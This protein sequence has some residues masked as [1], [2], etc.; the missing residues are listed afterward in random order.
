MG[1]LCGLR[2]A[3]ARVGG[4]QNPA[5][6]RS[7][8]AGRRSS[9]RSLIAGRCVHTQPG[10]A[11][12]AG[13]RGSALLLHDGLVD[14]VSI[15]ENLRPGYRVRVAERDRVAFLLVLARRAVAVFRQLATA[16]AALHA[17]GKLHRDLKPSN[18][19]VDRT[20]RLVV[21][22]FGLVRGRAGLARLDRSHCWKRKFPSLYPSRPVAAAGRQVVR[23]GTVWCRLVRSAHR[24][25]SVLGPVAA[26]AGDKQLYT[27]RRPSICCTTFLRS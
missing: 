27:P 20:G 23:S 10:S 15:L 14:G 19:L 26:G 2:T 24:L 16:V 18:I 7:V 22:D 6:L 12:R 4:A 5:F 17:H 9:A 21:L 25:S 13:V 3:A 11:L 1:G 8:L